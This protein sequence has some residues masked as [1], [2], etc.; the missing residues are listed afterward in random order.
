MAVAGLIC[1]ILSLV[2]AW[3]GYSAFAGLALGIVGI[4]LCSKGKKADPSKAG[5]CTAGLVLSIIG[6]VLCGIMSIACVICASAAS[7]VSSSSKEFEDAL[8]E[9]LK[10]LN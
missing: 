2:L 10:G 6:V 1:G 9:A 5:M 7:A 4:I 8:N 3:F